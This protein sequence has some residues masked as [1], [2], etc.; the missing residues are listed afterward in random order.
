MYWTRFLFWSLI[1]N[2]CPIVALSAE[3]TS[4]D[5]AISFSLSDRWTHRLID[6]GGR[7]FHVV[8]RD[9]RDIANIEATAIYRSRVKDQPSLRN[10]MENVVVPN[11]LKSYS[12][13]YPYH[14]STERV[15]PVTLGNGIE[16]T[17][18]EYTLIINQ[19]TRSIVFLFWE[20]DVGQ[21]TVWYWVKINNA[22]WYRKLPDSDV[23][24]EVLAGIK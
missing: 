9:S 5:Y 14:V 13:E 6:T 16:A 24:K 22:G 3:T 10:W 19:N 11:N 8:I 20:R 23:F 4:K 17:A 12:G 18:R 7:Y 21:E 1:L 2:L 15:H